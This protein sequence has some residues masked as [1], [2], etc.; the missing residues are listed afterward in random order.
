M[1]VEQKILI[2]KTWKM[3]RGIDPS[4]IGDTFYSKLFN[5]TPGL[6]RMF[7]SNMDDQ[8]KK[9]IDMLSVIVARIDNLDELNEDITAMARRHLHYGVRPGHYKLVG[10][11]LLWTLEQ[12][13]GRDWSAEVEE[14]WTQCY[15]TISEIMIRASGEW[16][17]RGH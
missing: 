16:V 2:K 3:F 15:S 5:D 7:P 13:L 12:G 11:A 17:V 1:T 10:K 4:V 6:R 8:Y 9:L 14:A